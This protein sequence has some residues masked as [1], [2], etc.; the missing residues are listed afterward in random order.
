VRGSFFCVFFCACSASVAP[1]LA[2][3]GAAPVVT[4]TPP[5]ID[6]LSLADAGVK[7][8]RWPAPPSPPP[9]PP[10]ITG[11]A[12]V[13][14]PIALVFS[15]A[16]DHLPRKDYAKH[17]SKRMDA[18]L[19]SIE[20]KC[21]A[22]QKKHNPDFDPKRPQWVN[23]VDDACD[24]DRL[25]CGNGG[26]V[27]VSIVVESVKDGRAKVMFT[28]DFGDDFPITLVDEGGWKIDTIDCS[29]PEAQKKQKRA[30]SP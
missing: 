3:S 20:K 19:S 25:T 13:A 10:V 5:P 17:I 22:A 26:P 18:H 11:D 12:G 1:D 27:A 9:P 16:Y 6:G 30:S 7:T 28:T 23:G 24:W 14:A 2:D 29:W 8:P 4:T 15:T 21:V